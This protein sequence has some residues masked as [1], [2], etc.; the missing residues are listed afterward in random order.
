MTDTEK[1]ESPTV[2]SWEKTTGQELAKAYADFLDRQKWWLMATG[3]SL[4]VNFNPL[5]QDAIEYMT[6]ETAKKDKKNVFENIGKNIKKK[7]VEKF[8]GWTF[9]EYDKASLNKMRALIMQYKNDE[10]KLQELK[11]QIDAGTD[12]TA[13]KTADADV[14]KNTNTTATGNAATAAAAAGTWA[15]VENYDKSK[16][17]EPIDIKKAEITSKFGKRTDPVTWEKNKQHNGVDIAAPQGTSVHNIVSG[18][19]IEDKRDTHGWGNFVSV[20]WDDGRTYL[21]LH[22]EEKPSDLKV[23]DVVK[24][25]D[26]IGKVGSTGKSTWPHLHLTVKENNKP[27]DPM[28]SLPEILDKYKMKA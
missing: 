28:A 7:F 16:Y 22:L 24:A 8:T 21:Y 25:G 19:V 26:E 27:V 20:Q 5:K 4:G 14:S 18:K 15:V 13:E 9:I 11:D 1:Q 12:P 2:E 23:G 10:K 6:A 3:A 17:Q